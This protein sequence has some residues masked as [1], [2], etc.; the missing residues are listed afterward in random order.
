MTSSVVVLEVVEAEVDLD[1]DVAEDAVATMT[2]ATVAA[3]EEDMVAATA[4]AMTTTRATE[5]D[6]AAAMTTARATEA[7]M[8]IARAMEAMTTAVM[9][10]KAMETTVVVANKAVM[11]R[12]R[13]AGGGR[14]LLQG[15]VIILTA[16]NHE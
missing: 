1:A 14:L 3:T 12:A 8:T 15:V 7:D 10:T 5:A 4:V 16:V 9:E 11:A 2:G 13:Q 6:M